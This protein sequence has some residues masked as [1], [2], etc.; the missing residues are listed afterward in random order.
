MDL[1]DAIQT[2]S[3]SV[4]LPASQISLFYNTMILYISGYSH[5]V[6]LSHSGGNPY[7][8]LSMFVRVWDYDRLN[9]VFPVFPLWDFKYH[10]KIPFVL[11]FLPDK[12]QRFGF[13]RQ[14]YIRYVN[15]RYITIGI[16]CKVVFRT[17]RSD[18][19]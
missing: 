4:I 13:E 1:F 16:D 8:G 2:L 18:P 15:Y 12:S 10:R 5:T 6:I 7:L 14:V 3:I 11:V 9:L 17:N 19:N